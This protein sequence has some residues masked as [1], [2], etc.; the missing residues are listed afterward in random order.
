MLSKGFL[1]DCD[2][3]MMRSFLND[4]GWQGMGDWR[5]M[6]LIHR[7]HIYLALLNLMLL[8][9]GSFIGGDGLMLVLLHVL[10]VQGS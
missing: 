6:V 10:H 8:L 9:L 1:E 5:G 4:D 7:L 2:E 3:L